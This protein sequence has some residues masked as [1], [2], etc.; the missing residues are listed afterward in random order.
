MKF[1][2]L[3]LLVF[4]AACSALPEQGTPMKA[5]SGTLLFPGVTALP[6]T[7]TAHIAIVPAYSQGAAKPVA[8][9]DFPAPTGDKIPF[10]LKFPA[11]SVADGG[12]YLV[13]AQVIDH[14]KVWY[15]NISTPV[16]I[17]FLAEP[18]EL[19]IEMRRERL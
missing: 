17:R 5:L 3:P 4:L 10:H 6:T 19:M 7:A 8:Q 11:A 1:R 16:R 18:G 9:G 2:L 15:S 14:G 12:E 13:F